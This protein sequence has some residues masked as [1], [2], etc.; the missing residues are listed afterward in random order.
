MIIYSGDQAT[1][2]KLKAPHDPD[3]SIDYSI[4]WAP[5]VWSAF[6]VAQ[7]GS[8]VAPTSNNGFYGLCTSGGITGSNEPTWSTIKNGKV[9]DGDVEWTMK[10]CDRTSNTTVTHHRYPI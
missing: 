4:Y 10:P 8:I 2:V 9:E 7:E 1:P 5:P 3:D 6:T